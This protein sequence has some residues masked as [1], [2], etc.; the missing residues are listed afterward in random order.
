MSQ[1]ISLKVEPV[2]LNG[3]DGA[4]T[5]RQEIC[6]IVSNHRRNSDLPYMVKIRC[7]QFER[8]LGIGKQK[9]T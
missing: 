1:V 8:D 2:A 5:V 3:M 4:E 6:R 7:K 9:H